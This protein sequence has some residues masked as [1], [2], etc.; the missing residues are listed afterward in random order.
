[1]I[2]LHTHILPG[3][4]DGSPDM[5]TSLEM[6]RI[7]AAHQTKFIFATPH[8]IQGAL[9]NR[10]EKVLEHCEAFNRE[11]ASLG[12]GLTVLPGCEL[13]ICPEAPELVEE[14]TVSALG[15]TSL[16][17]VEFPMM[18]VPVYT[19][20]VLYRMKLKGFQPVLAHPE[21]NREIAANPDILYHLVKRGIL[22]QVNSTSITG[23]YG[24][25]VQKTAL[26]LI[27]HHLVHFAASDAHTCRGRSPKLEQA[28]ALVRD[29]FGDETAERL[30][31]GNARAF[32]DGL[33]PE[34]PEPMR[35]TSSRVFLGGDIFGSLRKL[36]THMF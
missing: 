5:E 4:D 33:E 20:E 7:A 32:L 8:Y 24:K 21:R 6:A 31:F 35:V 17:L 16:V 30:F 19:D 12:I 9:E 11:L 15:A 25:T 13:F 36:M 28:S 29:K 18:S 27:R 23:L 26:S 10:R 34:L 3:I 22:A 1:M 2:D 14:G